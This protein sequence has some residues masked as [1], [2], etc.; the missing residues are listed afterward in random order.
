MTVL[1]S[2]NDTSQSWGGY[3][4]TVFELQNNTGCYCIGIVI[5]GEA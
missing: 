5:K 4:D 1:E 2:L 3:L